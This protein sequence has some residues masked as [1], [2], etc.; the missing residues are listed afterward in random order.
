MERLKKLYDV[1]LREKYYTNSFEEFQKKF[2][3]PKYVQKVYEVVKR[4][5]LYTKSFEDFN[6]TYNLKKKDSSEPTGDQ[7]P[8]ESPSQ[9]SQDPFSSDSSNEPTAPIDPTTGLPFKDDNTQVVEEDIS[10][11]NVGDEDLE[12]LPS[13][14]VNLVNVTTLNVKNNNINLF[15]L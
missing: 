11:D 5:K 2:E 9:P 1:L 4:D 12:T 8:M 13:T 15:I 7:V 3:D 14:F 6:M 10:I